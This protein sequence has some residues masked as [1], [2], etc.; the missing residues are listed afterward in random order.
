[1][2]K[3][4]DAMKEYMD[5]VRSIQ[6]RSKIWNIYRSGKAK[7]P[8]A[9][10]MTTF[11][12]DLP[13][14]Y[15]IKVGG[16]E[17]ESFS[18][19]KA[20]TV[21]K[22]KVITDSNINL[23]YYYFVSDGAPETYYSKKEKVEKISQDTLANIAN[24]DWLKKFKN[25]DKYNKKM[26]EIMKTKY[27]KSMEYHKQIKYSEFYKKYISYDKYMYFLENGWSV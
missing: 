20:I 18:R 21:Y 13:Y 11:G 25:F 10:G 23:H 26:V 8:Y 17:I 12:Y 1:M 6:K 15:N 9:V 16:F 19:S 2:C 4:A 5:H 3:D 24:K 27:I 22:S 14:S 7:I